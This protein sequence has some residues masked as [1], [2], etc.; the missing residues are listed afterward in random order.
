MNTAGIRF[1]NP[2]PPQHTIA[3]LGPSLGMQV[4]PEQT[5]LATC[6]QPD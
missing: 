6:T 4:K 2:F 3:G 1:L 5:N